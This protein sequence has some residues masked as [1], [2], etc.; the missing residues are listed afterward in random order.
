MTIPTDQICRAGGD[1]K[2]DIFAVLRIA[3]N[4]VDMRNFIN[5][6]G[7]TCDAGKKLRNMFVSQGGKFLFMA[8]AKK[9]I[10]HVGENIGANAKFRGP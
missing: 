7:S 3:I 9:Y 2:I 4:R 1:R 10:T 5:Q 6:R 8:R